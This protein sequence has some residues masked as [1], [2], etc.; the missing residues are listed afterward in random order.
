MHVASKVDSRECTKNIDSFASNCNRTTEVMDV[1][2]LKLK[3]Y[4]SFDISKL[5][6]DSDDDD[7][8]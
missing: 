8:A 3:E 4:I 2:T 7:V 6:D 5:L 1:L